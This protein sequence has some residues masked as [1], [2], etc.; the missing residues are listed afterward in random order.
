[1]KRST[2]DYIWPIVGLAAVAFSVWML[3]NQLR[4][5]SLDDI[6]NSLYAIPYSNW[7]FA[8]LATLG[9]YIALAGYDWLALLHLRKRLPWSFI[10]AASFTAYAM[11]HNIGASVFSGAVVRYRAYR[12][13]DLTPAEVGILVA[14]CSFTFSLGA[15]FLGGLVLLLDPGMIRRFFEDMPLWGSITLSVAMLAL[16][17]LYVLGSQLR[18][19]PLELRW[20][21]L[22][23]PEPG[24]VWRQLIIGPLELIAAAAIIYFALPDSANVSF[25]L[26]LGIFLASFSMALVSHAPGG[27]GVLEI[28]F[29]IGLPELDPADLIAA[30]LVFRLLYLLIP[31][32]LSL[33]IVL[34]F[35][36]DQ[37]L[38]RRSNE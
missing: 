37:W 25:L 7:V 18:F 26:V 15:I 33:V 9:A 3:I 23:Y 2:K 8:G 5:I 10:T 32:A 27:L 35:E 11:G 20:F 19:K 34:W 17:G 16:V 31:F 1:M 22:Q 21:K 12:S 29:L 13:K 14:F 38:R 6:I 36:R 24:I 4:H 28:C 30:L